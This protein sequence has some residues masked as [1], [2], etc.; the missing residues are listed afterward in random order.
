MIERLGAFL[1]RDAR[2]RAWWSGYRID[3][4]DALARPSGDQQLRGR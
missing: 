3:H 1:E 2:W 4:Y